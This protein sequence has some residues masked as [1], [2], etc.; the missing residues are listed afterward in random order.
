[1]ASFAT[2]SDFLARI[3]EK[4]VAPILGVLPGG[5]IGA[6]EQARIQAA[7]DD[8]TAEISS[9]EPRV[10]TAH[11]PAADTLLIHCC[12][13]AMYLLTLG[14]PGKEFEQIRNAYNDTIKFY[15]DAIAAAGAGGGGPPVEG[16]AVIPDPV[17]TPET[18]K[19]FV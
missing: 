3:D 7:L 12:K 19:G 4:I 2:V 6:T 8:A 11:W 18:L 15:T 14:R 17:F 10:P 1:M 5:S 9:Y 16:S 13:V